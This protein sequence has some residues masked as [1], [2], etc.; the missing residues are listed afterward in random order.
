MELQHIPLWLVVIMWAAFAVSMAWSGIFASIIW[1][2]PPNTSKVDLR[3][4]TERLF[5]LLLVTFL[6][7]AAVFVIILFFRK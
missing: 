7:F 6:S 2:K 1:I 5:R 3:N 4:P